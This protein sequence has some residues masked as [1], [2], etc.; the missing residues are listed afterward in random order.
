ML[1]IDILIKCIHL[2]GF[3]CSA[4]NAP[5]G[6]L[7]LLPLLQLLL[8]LLQLLLLNQLVG[9]N[10]LRYA[11]DYHAFVSSTESRISKSN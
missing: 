2:I 8:L 3:S 4:A 7:L 10:I 11:N 9:L 6:L 5:D 1:L